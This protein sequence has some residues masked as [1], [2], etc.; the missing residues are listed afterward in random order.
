MLALI[1]FSF[2]G[3]FLIK[4]TYEVN[5][6]NDAVYSTYG[7]DSKADIHI[8]GSY[9]GTIETGESLTLTLKQGIHDIKIDIYYY[10]YGWNYVETIYDTIDIYSNEHYELYDDFISSSKFSSAK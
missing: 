1:V 5:F 7:Y 8:E 10:Y 4:P 2:S 9:K 3:C 6:Y